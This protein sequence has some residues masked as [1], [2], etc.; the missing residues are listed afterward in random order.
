MRH[1]RTRHLHTHIHAYKYK[2]QHRSMPLLLQ[3]N[4]NIRNALLVCVSAGMTSLHST[5][6]YVCGCVFVCTVC[7]LEL[8][9]HFSTTCL[10]CTHKAH[11]Q[12]MWYE[13]RT[14]PSIHTR[15]HTCISHAQAHAVIN[16]SSVES[17]AYPVYKQRPGKIYTFVYFYYFCFF[18]IYCICFCFIFI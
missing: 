6:S 15:T 2:S 8:S 13:K 18:H 11:K 5:K 12:A 1:P 4:R 17:D 10:I 9:M 16:I 3:Q 7:V 14:H